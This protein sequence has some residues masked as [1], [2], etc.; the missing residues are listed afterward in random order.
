MMVMVG[1]CMLALRPLSLSD[2]IVVEKE[3]EEEW[4]KELL[5]G[6]LAQTLGRG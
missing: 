1:W 2:R 5:R 4:W 6:W 3:E